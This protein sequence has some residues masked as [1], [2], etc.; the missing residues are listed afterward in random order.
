ME[1]KSAGNGCRDNLLMLFL[2]KFS[3]CNRPLFNHTFLHYGKRVFCFKFNGDRSKVVA[4]CIEA[5]QVNFENLL[6]MDGQIIRSSAPC[7]FD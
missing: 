6:D 5:L 7:S 1:Q 2:L 4:L 3:F